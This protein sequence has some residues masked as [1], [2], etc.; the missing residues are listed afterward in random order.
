M[1]RHPVEVRGALLWVMNGLAD[2]GGRCRN[3]PPCNQEPVP[4]LINHR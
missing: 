3:I 1:R 2:A 4:D